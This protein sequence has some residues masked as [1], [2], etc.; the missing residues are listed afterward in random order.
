[1]YGYI[2]S[3]NDEIVFT[4]SDRNCAVKKFFNYFSHYCALYNIEPAETSI[5]LELN[6]FS[7]NK[8][9]YVIYCSYK[10]NFILELS[11]EDLT[12]VD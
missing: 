10:H 1:M 7:L 8:I 3:L 2:I 6:A 12:I 4:T 9:C 11:M 5:P